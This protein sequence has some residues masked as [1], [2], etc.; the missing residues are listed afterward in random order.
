MSKLAKCVGT[1]LH[2]SKL[3]LHIMT[4]INDS[5]F[6]SPPIMALVSSLI[7]PHFT[8]PTDLLDSFHCLFVM[9]R[10]ARDELMLETVFP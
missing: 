3:S 4:W 6:P 5:P 8:S 10:K 9:S 7:Q 2:Q 1:K